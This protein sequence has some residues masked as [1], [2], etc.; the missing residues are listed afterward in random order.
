MQTSGVGMGVTLANG[1][2]KVNVKIGK[3]RWRSHAPLL[4]FTAPDVY[5]FF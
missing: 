2:A 1:A 5:S 3:M 4:Y